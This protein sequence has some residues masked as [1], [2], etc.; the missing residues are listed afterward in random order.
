[1]EFYFWGYPTKI[2]KSIDHIASLFIRVFGILAGNSTE[3]P[4]PECMIFS[5]FILR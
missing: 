4:L 1:M 2:R 3:T 5:E